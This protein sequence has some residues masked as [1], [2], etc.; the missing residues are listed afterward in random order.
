MRLLPTLMIASAFL[1]GCATTTVQVATPGLPSQPPIPEAPPVPARGPLLESVSPYD[2]LKLTI[3]ALFADTLFPPSNVGIIVYSLDRDETLYELNSNM[4]FNPASNQK[5][6]TAA[7][8]LTTL[9]GEHPL[10]T[11]V[12]ADTA[13]DVLCIRGEG[14]PL[15]ST[16]DLD[17]LARSIA[18]A[19][20]R[21]AEWTL[22]VDTSPFDDLWW[23][24]GWTWDSEPDAYGM[25]LSPLMLNS[26]TI[27]V[28][29]SPAK[30]NGGPPTVL[31]D[32]PSSYVT[33]EN[34]AVTVGDSPT[35]PLRVSRKWR[36]RLNT[37]TVTGETRRGARE[38]QTSISVWD[39]ARYAG[40]MFAELLTRYGAPV[41]SVF[42]DT[43]PLPG[44]E[45]GRVDHRVDSAV[46]FMNK[47][48]DNL[49]AEALLKVTGRARLGGRGSAESGIAVLHQLLSSYGIDTLGIRIADGSGLS[50][51]NL[52]SPA[53]VLTLLRAM[54][55]D[56]RHF[57]AFYA[58]LPIAGVDGTIS[59]RMRGTPAEGNLR[60]KTGSLS[61]VS[62][63][64]GYVRTRDNEM[65]AFSILMQN[66]PRGASAYRSVQDRIGS[67]LAGLKREEFE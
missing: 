21:R 25:F 24:E 61:A 22:R 37:V 35:I 23:G 6:F 50:R 41:T 51:Y 56:D 2:D 18:S 63:L 66:F 60:A 28:R 30:S 65:L 44:V 5:L 15:L 48:S 46:T 27:E 29:V 20:P 8:A 40:T 54:H 13:A 59:R 33:V 57:P 9:G 62:T 26:N 10:S 19:L 31:I 34:T 52:T 1:A 38:Y 58:S 43:L 17:T 12:L 45:V 53:A 16:R 3:D 7:G 42:V 67:T 64:S 36:E 47:E 32:P 11:I 39:P 4:L 55:A 14:D 49:S